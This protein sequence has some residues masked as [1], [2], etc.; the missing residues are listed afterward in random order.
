MFTLTAA[1][2]LLIVIDKFQTERVQL[3]IE[4]KLPKAITWLTTYN[5]SFRIEKS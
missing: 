5:L 2:I 4:N 1:R 3:I